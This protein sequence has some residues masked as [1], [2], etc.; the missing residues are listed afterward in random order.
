MPFQ[1]ARTLYCLGERLRRGRRRADARTPLREALAIF[2]RLGAA[3]WAAKARTELTATGGMVPAES[4][5]EL[6]ELTPHEL[7]VAL[8]VAEGRTNREVAAALFLA[9]KTIE[10]HLSAIF[11]KL[12]I[13]RRTE[14]AR[15]FA[16]DLAA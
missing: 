16:G 10:H 11:R 6:E 1:R 7:K 8:L 2:Q 13:R 5:P 14:L 12:G 9:P 15:F 3:D 4:R